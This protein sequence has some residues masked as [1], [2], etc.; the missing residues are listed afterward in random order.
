MEFVVMMKRLARP[1]LAV[2][3][4]TGAAA[5]AVPTFALD[6]GSAL[7]GVVDTVTQDKSSGTGTGAG[8]GAVLGLST[9]DL[10]AGLKEALRVG[11]E[12]VAGRLGAVDGFNTDPAVHIPLPKE[13]QTVR[14]TLSRIGLA[15]LADEVELK[16]NRGAEAAM[17]KAKKLVTDAIV[18]MSLDD[19]KAI[20]NGPKDAAT[21]YFRRVSAHDLEATVAPVINSALQD[22]GA[23]AAYDQLVGQY[24]T[25]PFVPDLKADLTAHATRLALDGLFLYLAA[26]ESAI[27]ENPAKRTSEILAKVFGAH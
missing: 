13:L 10:T 9:A 12:T 21:Q 5:L 22:V 24:A 7:K 8:A 3:V 4:F 16:L 19:A 15:S 23:V 6:W 2:M 20:F 25:L 14:S 26:E 1:T 27:R 11:A 17:P 18:K